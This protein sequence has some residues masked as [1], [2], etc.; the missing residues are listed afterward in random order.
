MMGLSDGWVT[1][2]GLPRTAEMRALGNGVVSQ[3]AGH[4][5]RLLEEIFG[6]DQPIGDAP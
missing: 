5:L 1:G 4:G 6:A 3:Q 2:I